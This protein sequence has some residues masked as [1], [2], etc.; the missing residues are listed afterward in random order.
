MIVQ[1]AHDFTCPWCWIGLHQ[2]KRLQKDYGVEIEWLGYELYPEEL[3]W[4][5]PAAPVPEDPRRPKIASRL[6]LAYAAEAM[7][8]PAAPRPRG[9]RTHNAHEAVEYAK[10][11][12]VAN[13]LVD[14]LY[15][16]L[17]LEGLEIAHPEVL[18]DLAQGIVG[19]V[20]KMIEAFEDRR[21]KTRIVGFDEPAYASGI[22]NVPTFI[23]NGEK[24]AEQP[25]V[26]I[27]KAFETVPATH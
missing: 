1:I 2:A 16:A 3:P 19:N 21:F 5:T 8:P 23:I 14:R 10:T 11:E 17:W 7:Q 13:A 20:P 25:Y 26:A 22:F 9:M 27:I 15:E 24:Y 18:A 4:P 12:G 6:E